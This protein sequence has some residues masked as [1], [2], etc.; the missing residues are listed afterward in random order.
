MTD[1]IRKMSPIYYGVEGRIRIQE[2]VLENKAANHK[3]SS[4]YL[5]SLLLLIKL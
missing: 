3:I 5:I 2:N 1:M 4:I